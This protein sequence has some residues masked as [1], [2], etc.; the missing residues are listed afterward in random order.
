MIKKN[1]RI[2]LFIIP[3]IVVGLGVNIVFA[4]WF[5]PLQTAPEGNAAA[6]LNVGADLQTKVGGLTVGNTQA[7]DAGLTVKGKTKTEGGLIIETRTGTDP[8]GVD[9]VP[10]RMWLRT[11]VTVNP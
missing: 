2:S 8:S 9:L 11:D 6:P 3:A 5:V 1:T 10:G 7:S 4:G